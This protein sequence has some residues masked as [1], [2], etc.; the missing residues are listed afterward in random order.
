MSFTAEEIAYLRSQPCVATLAADG[1]PDAVPLAFEFDGTYF[2]K[3][4]APAASRPPHRSE[5][6]ARSATSS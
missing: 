3:E 1:R 4:R 5:R 6:A 2:W